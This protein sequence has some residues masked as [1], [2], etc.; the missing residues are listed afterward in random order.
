MIL[1]VARRLVVSIAR[2]NIVHTLWRHGAKPQIPIVKQSIFLQ[3]KHPA[4]YISRF[5]SLGIRII[6]YLLHYNTV[7]EMSTCFQLPFADA[8]GVRA[9]FPEGKR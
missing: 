2:S 1:I 5:F 9:L 6:L 8:V 7:Y 4:R 3:L